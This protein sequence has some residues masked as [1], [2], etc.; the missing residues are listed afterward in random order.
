MSLYQSLQANTRI[1]D[2]TE[3]RSHDVSFSISN[4]A[5]SSLNDAGKAVVGPLNKEE[6]HVHKS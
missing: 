2:K 4:S 3:W 1:G 5:V 6:A